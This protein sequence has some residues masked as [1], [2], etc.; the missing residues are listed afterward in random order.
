M[1]S[2]NGRQNALLAAFLGS[3]ILAL[4][5]GC[6]GGGGGSD[7]PI[8]SPT[9][10]TAIPATLTALQSQVFQPSCTFSSCHGHASPQ[11]GFDTSSAALVLATGSNQTA[12]ETFNGAAVMRITPGNHAASYVWLKVTGATGIQGDRMP[13]TGQDISTC[14]VTALEQ[15]IDAGA[16]NN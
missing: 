10:C 11:N 5:A 4:A 15:W 2:L 7:T 14:A 9:P 13:S 16:P 12:Q 8:P 6:S 1:R 3:S